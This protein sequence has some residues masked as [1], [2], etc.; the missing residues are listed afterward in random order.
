MGI[1]FDNTAQSGS[2]DDLESKL[3]HLS[4]ELERTFDRLGACIPVEVRSV[5][6]LT[7]CIRDTEHFLTLLHQ[8]RRILSTLGR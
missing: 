1:S 2:N 4:E 5:E 3:F 6:D 7:I 8:A